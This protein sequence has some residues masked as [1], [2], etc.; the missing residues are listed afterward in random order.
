M[1]NTEKV[2]KISALRVE[3]EII[4]SDKAKKMIWESDNKFSD[5]YKLSKLMDSTEGY[6]SK[7]NKL[8]DDHLNMVHGIILGN[9]KIQ[10]VMH[11]KG[12]EDVAEFLSVII[13]EDIDVI[14]I[15]DEVVGDINGICE[16]IQK[17]HPDYNPNDETTWGSNL[18]LSNAFHGLYAHVA[19]DNRMLLTAKHMQMCTIKKKVFEST[20][21][22]EG[23][24]KDLHTMVYDVLDESSIMLL[25]S[26]IHGKMVSYT[27]KVRDE[28]YDYLVKNPNS[29][30]VR[31]L[32]TEI[33]D[34][35]VAVLT[36]NFNYYDTQSF[37]LSKSFLAFR[38]NKDDKICLIKYAGNN[39]F[40]VKE[41]N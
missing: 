39:Q 21:P 19:E 34:A 28:I 36:R 1:D 30:A 7:L 9:K 6:I 12:K 20:V 13:R 22:V 14:R 25:Y 2:G 16:S 17:E 15:T 4:S 18:E 41:I 40:K 3:L 33:T 29:P 11:F 31:M 8:S 5:R 27:D 38:K 23:G 26:F 35:D 37:M 10:K 24:K 32:T